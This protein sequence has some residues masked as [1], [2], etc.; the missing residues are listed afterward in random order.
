MAFSADLLEQLTAISSNRFCQF[1]PLL[2]FFGQAKI[3]EA[4][5]IPLGPRW[6][7]VLQQPLWRDLRKHVERVTH[8]LSD[9]FEPTEPRL[10]DHDWETDQQSLDLRTT[11]L[12]HLA[13]AST[14]CP[15]AG[16]HVQRG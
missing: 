7:H 1:C 4:F 12:T 5:L 13:S 15:G 16:R 14:R 10:A 8:G 6:I 3:T 11:F 2:L 9:A